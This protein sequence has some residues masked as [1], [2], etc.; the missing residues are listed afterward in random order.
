MCV[1]NLRNFSAVKLEMMAYISFVTS[2]HPFY[3]YAELTSNISSWS[4]VLLS[5]VF[6][7]FY[8]IPASVFDT[9]S[10]WF[11][12][13]VARAGVGYQRVVGIQRVVQVDIVKDSCS[14]A[15]HAQDSFAR[16]T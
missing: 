8:S 6:S 11:P 7:F 4:L 15:A 12:L 9:G 2:L 13:H 10:V 14:T 1:G 5:S 3:L 16:T